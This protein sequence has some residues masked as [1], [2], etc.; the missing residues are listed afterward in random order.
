M[1]P[2]VWT[3]ERYEQERKGGHTKLSWA[4]WNSQKAWKD[5]GPSKPVEA[6]VKRVVPGSHED[7]KQRKAGGHTKMSWA[8]WS[9]AKA[10]K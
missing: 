5:L 9:K 3:H 2:A 7:W 8:D 6:K 1:P 10:W 4:D